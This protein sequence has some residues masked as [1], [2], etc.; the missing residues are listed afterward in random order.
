VCEKHPD[1]LKY[2]VKCED[3]EVTFDGPHAYQT[4]WCRKHDS[5]ESAV[6]SA[7]DDRDIKYKQQKIYNVTQHGLGDAMCQIRVDFQL[8]DFGNATISPAVTILLECDETQHSG[9]PVGPESTRALRAF[10]VFDED[11]VLLFIR[12]NVDGYTVDGRKAGKKYTVEDRV[13][14]VVQWLED[15]DFDDLSSGVHLAYFYYSTEKGSLALT[16]RSAFNADAKAA[17]LYVHSP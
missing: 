8:R 10:E 1:Y 12:L 3:C 5:K 7:F 13:A 17:I 9:Y 4:H 2:T 14:A 16:K 15:L 11:D 6:K